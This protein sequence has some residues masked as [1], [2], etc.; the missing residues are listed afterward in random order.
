MTDRTRRARSGSGVRCAR[1]KGGKRSGA[2]RTPRLQAGQAGLEIAAS[3]AER[4]GERPSF[5]VS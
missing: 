5:E 3:R 2:G 4:D 1:L